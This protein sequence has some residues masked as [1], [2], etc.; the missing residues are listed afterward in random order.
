MLRR[1]EAGRWDPLLRPSFITLGVALA[2]LGVVV[3]P[4][5]G[6]VEGAQTVS[7]YMVGTGVVVG[8]VSY[9]AG[10]IRR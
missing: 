4:L 1:D 10:A 6:I 8:I 2:A 3:A 5:E 7:R 9:L